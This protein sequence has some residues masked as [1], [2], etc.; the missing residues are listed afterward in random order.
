MEGSMSTNLVITT[1]QK[2]GK[3]PVT[4]FHMQGN[5]DTN[6]Y[7]QL[8]DQA[9]EAIQSGT[10]NLLLD[11]SEVS[12]ISSAG[13][14]A[15]HNIYTMLRNKSLDESDELVS[16]GLM[17]GSYKSH[18]LKLLNPSKNVENVLKTAGFDMYIGSYHNLQEAINSF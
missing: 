3:T 11:L 8:L 14:R 16:K 1:E 7:Q 13:L 2:I 9:T 12:Y 15:L 6:T 5:I 18:H 10:R 4:I 17:D